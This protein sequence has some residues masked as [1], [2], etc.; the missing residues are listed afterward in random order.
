[1]S[2]ARQLILE[3]DEFDPK[4]YADQ[5]VNEPPEFTDALDDVLLDFTNSVKDDMRKALRS[6]IHK[7]FTAPKWVRRFPPSMFTNGYGRLLA[8]AVLARAAEKNAA[9]NK[10][11]RTASSMRRMV[12]DYLRFA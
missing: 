4:S 10:R 12:D 2:Q 9:S 5:T 11:D 3:N 8:R 1:M 6:G 7:N